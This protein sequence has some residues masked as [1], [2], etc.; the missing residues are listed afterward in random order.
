M[1]SRR[2][3]EEEDEDIDGDAAHEDVEEEWQD[4]A[5]HDDAAAEPS[6]SRARCAFPEEMDV[7]R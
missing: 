3:A 5:A 7:R 4:D 6:K 1:E 2:R